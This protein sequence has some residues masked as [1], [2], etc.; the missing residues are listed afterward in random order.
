MS[1]AQWPCYKTSL[2]TTDPEAKKDIKAYSNMLTYQEISL[3]TNCSYLQ[4]AMP[5]LINKQNIWKRKKSSHL[6]FKSAAIIWLRL[7][8]KVPLKYH[9][10]TYKGFNMTELKVSGCTS[11]KTS[12]FMKTLLSLCA[13]IICLDSQPTGCSLCKDR[14]E[15]WEGWPGR[16]ASES[17]V[18]RHTVG[19][20]LCQW[21]SH[22][23]NPGRGGQHRQT[24]SETLFCW[25][26]LSD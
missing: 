8:G 11:T 3:T 13:N 14:K 20:S 22:P 2:W 24:T 5:E 26:R 21:V 15:I 9:L 6:G 10:I 7:T 4:S 12:L 23:G 18:S 1:S 19:H 25:R 17:C 16:P